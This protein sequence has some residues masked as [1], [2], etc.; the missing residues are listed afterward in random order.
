MNQTNTMIARDDCSESDW[1]DYEPDWEDLVWLD[2][3]ERVFESMR[4]E[5]DEITR[6]IR[7]SAGTNR[8]LRNA[9]K[10][11]KSISHE[12]F[13]EYRFDVA[14]DSYDVDLDGETSIT[15]SRTGVSRDEAPHP[16]SRKSKRIAKKRIR[17]A[18][19]YLR[20][21]E[22]TKQGEKSLPSQRLGRQELF[23]RVVAAV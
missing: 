14:S 21:F 6:A 16:L 19:S 8:Q 5:Y 13:N 10:E 4:L 15:V 9:N 11:S 23:D 18:T 3:Q 17:R 2:Y 12:L 22:V 20:Q 1:E 7:A